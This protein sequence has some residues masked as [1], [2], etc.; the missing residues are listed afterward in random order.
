MDLVWAGD[1]TVDAAEG[2]GG[3][4]VGDCSYWTA[5][6]ATVVFAHEE[7]ALVGG[8]GGRG[9]HW[10]CDRLW[11][12]NCI[13]FCAI[14]VDAAKDGTRYRVGGVTPS[15][16]SV[17]IWLVPDGPVT[18]RWRNYRALRGRFDLQCACGGRC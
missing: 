3:S 16:V 2:S 12:Q 6:G 17:Q 14:F 7:G 15:I 8:G 11:P 13:D 10:R 18:S 1:S 4:G 9:G 5:L